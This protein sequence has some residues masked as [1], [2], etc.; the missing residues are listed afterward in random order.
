M[1]MSKDSGNGVAN[2]SSILK[3]LEMSYHI[4][5]NWVN[6][7]FQMTYSF[8]KGWVLLPSSWLC[9]PHSSLTLPLVLEIPSCELII[10]LTNLAETTIWSFPPSLQCSL[11]WV[12]EVTWWKGVDQKP[13]G[14]PQDKN[15]GPGEWHG[16]E[17]EDGDKHNVNTKMLTMC[18]YIGSPR[19]MRLHPST[20]F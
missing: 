7:W 18:C 4:I 9:S 8:C 1:P 3:S 16:K 10:H 13:S 14:P 20:I 11:C 17:R 5:W 19:L 2:C 6:F 12:S 15:R